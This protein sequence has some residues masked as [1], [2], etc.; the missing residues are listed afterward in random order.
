MKNITNAILSYCPEAHPSNPQQTDGSD[1]TLSPEGRYGR[2]INLWDRENVIVLAP[3]Q[4]VVVTPSEPSETDLPV[5]LPPTGK[6]ASEPS[7]FLPPDQAPWLPVA[8]QILDG[9]FEGADG[10][11]RE[12]LTIGL[13]SIQNPVCASAIKCLW[14]GGMPKHLQPQ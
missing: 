4:R 11:T 3:C 5:A 2:K 9:E 8:R 7:E 13:R 12:S 14:P 10:S 1:G 6:Q